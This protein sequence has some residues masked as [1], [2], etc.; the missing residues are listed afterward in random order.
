MNYRMTF[1]IVGQIMKVVGAA[2]LVPLI[3]GLIY[4]EGHV[5]AS[6]GIPLL[7]LLIGGFALTIKKTVG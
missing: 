1:Y 6:F 3:V 2:M 5:F 7:I 4:G